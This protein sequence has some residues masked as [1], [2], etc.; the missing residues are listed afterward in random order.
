[1]TQQHLNH[2]MLLCIHRYHTDRLNLIEAANDFANANEHQRSVFGIFTASDLSLPKNHLITYLP[3]NIVNYLYALT[4]HYNL[5]EWKF[6]CV[7]N[8]SK[9]I[10]L[11]FD[12]NTINLRTWNFQ[13]LLQ[14]SSAEWPNSRELLTFGS[15]VRTGS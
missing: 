13:L 5:L 7:G 6:I 4:M 12:H 10:N 11:T 15:D 3:V 1:M 8:K 9:W 14:L 2:L